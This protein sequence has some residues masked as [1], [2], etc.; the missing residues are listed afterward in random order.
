MAQQSKVSAGPWEDGVSDTVQLTDAANTAQRPTRFTLLLPDVG[1]RQDDDNLIKQLMAQ[2]CTRTYMMT[3]KANETAAIA[4]QNPTTITSKHLVRQSCRSARSCFREPR[5]VGSPRRRFLASRPVETGAYMPTAR[6]ESTE[7]PIQFRQA[8][9]KGS[10]I[11]DSN[12]ALQGCRVCTALEM[13]QTVSAPSTSLMLNSISSLSPC[14]PLF[15]HCNAE[16]LA[17]KDN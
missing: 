13:V 1:R 17:C 10:S 4:L 7:R 6:R 15:N 9:R 8:T 5:H 14:F 12:G 3:W 11:P 16:V 2:E